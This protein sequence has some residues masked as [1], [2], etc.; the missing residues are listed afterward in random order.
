MVFVLE[1]MRESIEIAL[2]H[3]DEIDKQ[4]ADTIIVAMC[5]DILNK[6]IL[7]I[8]NEKNWRDVETY[9]HIEGSQIVDECK[10]LE[11][12]F[13]FSLFDVLESA[14]DVDDALEYIKRNAIIVMDNELPMNEFFGIMKV[15]NELTGDDKRHFTR[16]SLDFVGRQKNVVTKR[17]SNYWASTTENKT[18][19]YDLTF[20][21]YGVHATLIKTIDVTF[22]EKTMH[23]GGFIDRVDFFNEHKETAVKELQ[24]NGLE[25]YRGLKFSV[26]SGKF[27]LT[28]SSALEYFGE[29]DFSF[30]VQQGS[31]MTSHNIRDI[32]E[33]EIY[34]RFNH[35]DFV[36]RLVKE[37]L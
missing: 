3:R 27:K 8:P 15:G 11:H 9:R 30:F 7:L 36:D 19:I 28:M 35:R 21:S 20:T 31:T 6:Y 4:F 14:D 37:F 12:G 25:L 17:I 18:D 33:W 34:V 16:R 2:K 1:Y 29:R 10:N 23:E 32:V 13:G 24:Q 26:K 22:P 5:N